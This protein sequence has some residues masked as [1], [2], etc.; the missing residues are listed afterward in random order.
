M[1]QLLSLLLVV[2]RGRKSDMQSQRIQL[3]WLT[4]IDDTDFSK[5]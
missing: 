1:L 2:M 5:H 4:H 3:C